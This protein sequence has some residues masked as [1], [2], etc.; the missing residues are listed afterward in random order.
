MPEKPLLPPEDSLRRRKARRSRPS[1]PQALSSR[2]VSR[3]VSRLGLAFALALTLSWLEAF[4]PP[5]PLPIPAFRYGLSNIVVLLVLLSEGSAPAFLIA[6]LKIAFTLML[7]GPLAALI[8]GC[9]GLLSVIA[10]S[11]LVRLGGRKCSYVLI[12]VSGA[13][14]HNLGQYLAVTFLYGISLRALL[15]ALL[16]IAYVSG[17]CCAYFV[18]LLHRRLQ[19]VRRVS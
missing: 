14:C 8:A 17:S 18:R 2:W 13:V 6:F 5:P 4:L 7:R 1:A 11:L 12:S 3:R 15:P 16:L 19:I 10:M 9:G